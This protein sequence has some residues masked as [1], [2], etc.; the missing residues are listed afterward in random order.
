MV[1]I[2][3]LILDKYNLIKVTILRHALL[4]QYNMMLEFTSIK[5]TKTA[6]ITCYLLVTDQIQGFK[7]INFS[8]KFFLNTSCHVC[9]EI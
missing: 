2:Y 7:F 8:F 6:L 9:L 5:H 1:L 4:H 3:V